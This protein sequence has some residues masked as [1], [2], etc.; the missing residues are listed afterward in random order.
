MATILIVD[1]RAANREYLLT[2]LSYSGYRL[3]EAGDGAEALAITRLERPDLVIADILMPTMDGYEFVRQLRA[4]PAVAATR[5]LFCTAH[6][7]EVEA[8]ALARACGVSGVLTKPCIA[9]QVLTAVEAALGGKAIPAKPVPESSSFDREHLRLL[10]DKL[11]EK[12]DELRCANERLTALVE[13]NLRLG[14][15]HDA[16]R[17][18]Q[19]FALAAR[20]IIGAR[21]AV[22]GLRDAV[23]GAS[24]PLFAS[25]MDAAATGRLKLDAR[26]PAL[27]RRLLLER[28][29]HRGQN[30]GG[31]PTALGLAPG[32]PPIQSWLTAPVRSPSK[33]YGWLLLIDK[34]G[35]DEFRDDDVRLAD[36]LSAQVGRIYE[37]S[38][39]FDKVVRQSQ[40]L[41]RKA[42]E[43]GRAEQRFRAVI[44]SA[45]DPMV[46]VDNDGI[47][48]IANERTEKVFGYPRSELIGRPVELL[49]P[50]RLH[51]RSIASRQQYLDDPNLSPLG[52]AME[53]IGRRKDGSEIPVEI[54]LS[55]LRT[56]D[57]VLLIIV[58]RNITERKRAETAL[59]RMQTRLEHVI[60]SNPAVIYSSTVENA[61]VQ[62]VSWVSGTVRDML[63]Y[64]P[65][66]TLTPD[67]WF[68]NIHPEDVARVREAIQRTLASTHDHAIDEY[69]FRHK[70]GAYR[71]VRS[72]MRLLRDGAGRPVEL[73]GSWSDITERKHL[74]DQI[75]QAQKMEAIGKLAG[76]VAHD[77]NNLLTVINGYS[78][79]LLFGVRPGDGSREPLEEIRKA[80]ERAAALTRQLLAFSRKAV[81]SPVVLDLNDL[82]TNLQ[83][84]L[85]RLIGEDIELK[86]SLA[87]G[88][89]RVKVDPGQMEQVVMNLVV[90]ARDAMP[91]GGKLILETANLELDAEYAEQ[92][93][94]T[95]PGQYVRL[96]VSDTG[97]G[98][99]AATQARIF[100]PFFTT[101][102]PDK[103]TGLGLSVVHW[104][105][106][107][108]GGRVEVYSEIGFGTTFKIYLPRTVESAPISRHAAHKI[109]R[110]GSETVLLVEDEAGVRSLARLILEKHGYLVL[111]AKNGE[112][113]VLISRDYT[114]RI[115]ILVTDTVMPKLSGTQAARQLAASRPKMKVLFL[116]GYTDDAIVHH[117][118]IDPSIPFLH[119][120]FS[121]EALAAKVR[122]VLDS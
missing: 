107:Q 25:G 5:I 58:I 41:T 88:L 84:M 121:S 14:S 11:S 71:W 22:V 23:D 46:I 10:T 16:G 114:G 30:P 38:N 29:S 50:D 8:K 61:A 109:A 73:V 27:R 98:M 99:D 76:G 75:L 18:L 94:E 33:T 100:E 72:E 119:K 49:I 40:E 79:L 20:E 67:W 68:A 37:S 122:E 52:E 45:P 102:G 78:E 118:L 113:A 87:L 54:N 32:Y 116:S 81:L 26:D 115:D 31:D 96:S 3:L 57:G 85:V 56:D 60:S 110:R 83:R 51:D 4:D 53:L 6:Y 34:I 95:Q 19:S 44:E 108:S 7:H 93:P 91:Q 42:A 12:A 64:M 69:R 47:I 90:N 104:I 55:P 117:G 92:H 13:L 24:R 48:A 28:S 39:L 105:I 112:E 111:E 74:E 9:E 35:A 15:E 77:F 43:S 106:K 70:G 120:P 82:L 36:I 1:D 103:G 80:G 2:L 89:W 63:G 17:L 66:E 86:S 101:K 97:V 21:Y 65:D 62:G 59:R